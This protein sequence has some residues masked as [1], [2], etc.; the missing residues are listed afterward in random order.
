MIDIIRTH[1]HNQLNKYDKQHTTIGYVT[2][3]NKYYHITWVHES[4]CKSTSTIGIYIVVSQGS[5]Y[6]S[7]WCFVPFR[8]HSYADPQRSV[9]GR[10]KFTWEI[11]V[12]YYHDNQGNSNSNSLVMVEQL[13]I[14]FANKRLFDLR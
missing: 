2:V 6:T 11:D 7:F 14:M 12:I 13:P 1:I 3:T 9:H 4:K 8:S 5:S 10:S